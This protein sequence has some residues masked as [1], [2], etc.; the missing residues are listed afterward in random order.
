MV[1]HTQECTALPFSKNK[2]L[3]IG[4]INKILKL[5]VANNCAALRSQKVRIGYA[6]LWQ[7]WG[8]APNMRPNAFR[9]LVLLFRVSGVELRVLG[10]KGLRFKVQSFEP[11]GGKQS[12]QILGIP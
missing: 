2:D 12:T 1:W 9:L 10:S 11:Q 4:P 3:P 5:Y 7:V 6:Q 8:L